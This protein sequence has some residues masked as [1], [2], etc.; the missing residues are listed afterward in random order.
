MTTEPTPREIEVLEA[1]CRF[2]SNKAAA[3]RL[4]RS[5]QTVKNVLSALYR[6]IGAD[7]AAQAAWLIWG[8][9]SEHRYQRTMPDAL[10]GS[11]M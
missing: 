10:H 11:L 9:E 8:P 7:S 2:G 5:E 3:H 1:V 6:K 4:G